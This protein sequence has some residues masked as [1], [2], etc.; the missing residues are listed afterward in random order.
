VAV[1]GPGLPYSVGRCIYLEQN[2]RVE[3]QAMAPGG[4]VT[5]RSPGEAAAVLAAGEN[6]GYER[7]WEMW[8]RRALGR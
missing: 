8:K 1:V 6:L 7:P 4:T 3:A 2:A 5:Y